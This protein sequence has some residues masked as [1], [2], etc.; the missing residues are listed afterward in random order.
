MKEFTTPLWSFTR[1][2]E[3]GTTDIKTF[4]ADTWS[5]ALQEFVNFVKGCGYTL[6]ED[7]VRISEELDSEYWFGNYFP[8]VED[9]WKHP[10][11]FCPPFEGNPDDCKFKNQSNDYSCADCEEE[12]DWDECYCNREDDIATQEMIEQSLNEI[13]QRLIKKNKG[14]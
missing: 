3:N 10:N 11:D 8:S 9:D 2:S 6:P 1:T 14:A 4:E 13:V 7:A 5:Q 12:I